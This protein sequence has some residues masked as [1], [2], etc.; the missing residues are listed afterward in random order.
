MYY[1]FC[2]HASSDDEGGAE[3]GQGG[4]MQ[5][6]FAAGPGG[7]TQP[8][9]PVLPD[10][11]PRTMCIKQNLEMVIS[12]DIAD[13]ISSLR[14]AE[15]GVNNRSGYRGV[16]RRPWG[17]WAAEI[18][19]PN[20]TTRRWLG[21]YDTAAEAARAYDAAAAAIRGANTRTNFSYPFQLNTTVT[22]R[23]VRRSAPTRRPVPL[24]LCVPVP[25]PQ[26]PQRLYPQGPGAAP[27][28]LAPLIRAQPVGQAPPAQLHNAPLGQQPWQV[29]QA[30]L[31]QQQRQ[32]QLQGHASLDIGL[33]PFDFFAR[34]LPGQ[35][36]QAALA[37]GLTPFTREGLAAQVAAQAGDSAPACTA[38]D[39]HTLDKELAAQRM[40]AYVL[41]AAAS[42]PGNAA[43]AAGAAACHLGR[44]TRS[45]EAPAALLPGPHRPPSPAWALHRVRQLQMKR[46]PRG[47]VAG[48]VGPD[49]QLPEFIR[50][51]STGALLNLA[52]GQHEAPAA[53]SFG[54]AAD[55]PA[56]ARA[57]TE[58]AA[59]ADSFCFHPQPC[60]GTDPPPVHHEL[61][62]FGSEQQGQAGNSLRDHHT[63]SCSTGTV[64]HS[65]CLSGEHQPHQP[66]PTPTS[67]RR[68]RLTSTQSEASYAHP[69]G[70]AFSAQVPRHPWVKQEPQGATALTG[71]GAELDLLLGEAAGADC[72]DGKALAALLATTQPAA[73]PASSPYGSQE[74]GGG[75]FSPKAG[76][77][78]S[79]RLAGGLLFSPTYRL[80]GL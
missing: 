53:P 10:D 61:H 40:P 22:G 34:H 41:G 27:E 9:G 6:G 17:K 55:A 28:H 64:H 52:P 66:H 62:C 54:Y 12:L 73:R 72:G 13:C 26:Q 76:L 29:Q 30:Q 33:S 16:R 2:S 67:M 15:T 11:T 68:Q 14:Q 5:Q 51:N 69:P 37:T 38:E 31:Q 70:Q 7:D 63:D 60:A 25:P 57:K 47:G 42:C 48:L 78:F 75:L 50:R 1:D 4:G 65:N 71:I 23:A 80:P 20:R 44:R 32:H 77:L 74:P 45:L 8:L 58:A 21:T 56:V 39:L 43:A 24:S 59:A 35:A 79:P 46:A 49:G 36:A 18:R 3:A 19:D